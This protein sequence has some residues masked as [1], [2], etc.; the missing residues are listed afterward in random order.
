MLLRYNLHIM[1]DLLP[2][3]NLEQIGVLKD[4]YKSWPLNL[5][6]LLGW[7]AEEEGIKEGS[8]KKELRVLLNRPGKASQTRVALKETVDIYCVLLS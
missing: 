8:R 6:N 5:L 3:L 2:K 4:I 7:L 1:F